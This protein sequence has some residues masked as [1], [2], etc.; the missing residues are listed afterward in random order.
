MLDLLFTNEIEMIGGV[1]A[2]DTPVSDHKRVE[3]DTRYCMNNCHIINEQSD[4]PS[5]PLDN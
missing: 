1:D 2:N 5:D 4:G 3:I